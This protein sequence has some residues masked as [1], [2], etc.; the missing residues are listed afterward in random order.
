MNIDLKS[1]VSM[2][3]VW[4]MQSNSE[5]IA[6]DEE[7][8][9]IECKVNDLVQKR[10]SSAR[11]Y[12]LPIQNRMQEE[13]QVARQSVL[14]ELSEL[15]GHCR[16]RGA[17]IKKEEEFY[18]RIDEVAVRILSSDQRFQQDHKTLS[19]ELSNSILAES[20]AICRAPIADQQQRLIE[21]LEKEKSY[22]R[23]GLM[24]D[25]STCLKCLGRGGET[26]T[27]K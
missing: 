22:K 11:S 3:D 17:L 18:Q 20:S 7:Y 26:S 1:L 9:E 21:R 12:A 5:Y 24:E 4:R 10:M 19:K 6:R 23:P 13:M 15:R 25:L 2:E 8:G 27:A 16:T 14:K